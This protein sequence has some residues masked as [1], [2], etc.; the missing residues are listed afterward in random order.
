MVKVMKTEHETEP[1]KTTIDDTVKDSS[2]G[3]EGFLRSVPGVSMAED[4]VCGF[5]MGLNWMSTWWYGQD[6]EL[7]KPMRYAGGIHAC[8]HIE[9][10]Y[11]TAKNGITDAS[12][13]VS[14]AHYAGYIAYTG[15][16][17]GAIAAATVYGP[18]SLLASPTA[19]RLGRIAVGYTGRILFSPVRWIVGEKDKSA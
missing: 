13:T 12:G 4:A 16:T 5:W 10:K 15:L 1:E 19:F 7:I 8:R 3:I 2:E 9:K 6:M 18:Y 17:I 11:K 14:A